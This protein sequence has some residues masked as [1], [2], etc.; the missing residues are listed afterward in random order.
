MTSLQE[1]GAE[2]VTVA[3]RAI[4]N[5]HRGFAALVDQAKRHGLDDQQIKELCAEEGM[6]WSDVRALLDESEAAA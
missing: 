3:A 4:V 2:L 5:A 1:S 6:S